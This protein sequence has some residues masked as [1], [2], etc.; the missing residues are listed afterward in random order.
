[1]MWAQVYKLPSLVLIFISAVSAL[2]TENYWTQRSKLLQKEDS[3]A[4]GGRLPYEPGE[5]IVNDI[6]MTAKRVELAKGLFINNC[7]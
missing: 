2:P 6:L 3:V 1:M 4:L 5:R 7:L